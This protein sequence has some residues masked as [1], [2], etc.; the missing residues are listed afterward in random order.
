MIDMRR[1]LLV[2]GF[3]LLTA[4]SQAES[5]PRVEITYDQ[6]A[7][8]VYFPG[9]F[10]L[11]QNN[12]TIQELMTIRHR[13]AS[14]LIYDKPS[15]AVK[16]C[17]SVGTKVEDKLLGMRKS[18]YWIL[19]AMASDKARMRNR[20]AMDLWLEFS[21]KPWY[22]DQEP[23][24]VNGYR[25]KMVEVYVNDSAQGIYCLMERVDRKQLKTLKYVDTLGVQGALYKNTTYTL[26]SRYWQ[27]YRNPMPTDQSGVWDGF[28]QKEPDWE[29]G[30][31]ICWQPLER[32][33][34]AIRKTTNATRFADTI[35]TH[36]DIP[37]FVDYVLF[38]QLLS[39]RDNV[40][41]N[42]YLSFYH[43]DSLKALYTPWDLDHAW[44]RQYNSS[45]EDIDAKLGWTSNYLYIRM[46]SLYNLDDTLSARYAE[47]RESYFT[48]EHID[49]LFAPYFELY[50]RT[51]MDT[52]EAQL[53]SGHN[54]IE[55]DIPSEQEYIHNWVV[56]RLEYLDSTYH[57]TPH[58]PT[59]PISTDITTTQTTTTKKILY[60]NTLYIRR[61][62][63]WYDLC[64]RKIVRD[65]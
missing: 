62:D 48:I 57:Y 25:G 26:L 18:H 39:A 19:D 29:D 2:I 36:L 14:S 8:D 16:L 22:Y 32:H 30:E 15:Y 37:V 59:P 27:D 17:D 54:N 65:E 10:K 4:Y 28:E 33:I 41:K 12:D 42:L 40:G 13:G 5:L 49:S 46:R 52:I 3:V 60:N 23:K 31:P 58:P 34:N 6:L 38:T 44:G 20:V 53:W 24:L 11:I 45:E 47:L 61:G 64:G 7:S 1:L 50:A 51:G 63:E 35:V 56:A 9:T 43:V 21:R 55:F